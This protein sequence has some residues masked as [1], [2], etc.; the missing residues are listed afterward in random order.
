MLIA[1]AEFTRSQRAGTAV[2][3][4]GKRS[5]KLICKLSSISF[6]VLLAT[7][8]VQTV[9]AA[10]VADANVAAGL[11]PTIINNPGMATQVDIQ[12]PSAGGVSRNVY[13]QFDVDRNG[14]ILNNSQHGAF[15][16]NGG[17]VAGNASL[18]QGAA[19]IILNEVNSSNP[20]QLNGLIE[21]AG[22]NAQVV[23][24]NPSGITCNGCGFINAN[25]ATLTTGQAQI[26]DGVLTGYRVEGGEVVVE[27]EPVWS[28][29]QDYT[30]I[31]ARSVKINT[32]MFAN[33]LKITTGLNNVDATNTNITRLDNAGSGKAPELSL[34]VSSL[35]GMYAGKITLVGTEKGVGVS[36]AGQIMADDAL[37]VLNENG[38]I[39]NTRY[40]QGGETLFLAAKNV[41]NEGE[42]SSEKAIEIDSS[43]AVTNNGH[44]STYSFEDGNSGITIKAASLESRGDI[45]TGESWQKTGNINIDTTDK[46]IATGQISAGGDLTMQGKTVNLSGSNTQANNIKLIARDGMLDTSN[47][48]VEASRQL[49]IA[50]GKLNNKQGILFGE[51]VAVTT[52]DIDNEYGNIYSRSNFKLKGGSIT[53]TG[54]SLVAW[55]SL[56]ITANEINNQA[57]RIYS[58]GGDVR[59]NVTGDV[60]NTDG[61]QIRANGKLLITAGGSVD[62][63]GEINSGAQLM[64]TAKNINNN[65]TLY[66]GNSIELNSD[67]A[68]TN[69]GIIQAEGDVKIAAATLN[70]RGTISARDHIR[71]TGNINIRTTGALIATGQNL[72]NGNLTMQGQTLDLSGSTTQA[73]NITLAASDTLNTSH[74]QVSAR[75]QLT[76]TAQKIDNKDGLLEAKVISV[77]ADSLDNQA[78]SILAISEL[79]L[80]ATDI[81]NE[82]GYVIAAGKDIFAKAP[83]PED[84]APSFSEWDTNGD[85]YR[86]ITSAI[87]RR[88]FQGNTLSDI[89]S[90]LYGILVSGGEI[91]S[92][93][94]QSW[95]SSVS[96]GRQPEPYEAAINTVVKILTEKWSSQSVPDVT[97]PANEIVDEN[98][99]IADEIV[100]EDK[101]IVDE[102]VD[103]DKGIADEIVDEDK[104][105]ADEIVDEDKGIA[106]EIVDE[107]KGIADEIVDEDK[108]I[109][110]EIVDEDKGIVDEIVDEDKG[111]A[112]EIVDEDKGI[113]DEIVDEDKGIADEIVD[114]DK[115]IADEIVDEDKGIADEIV[116]EDKGIA[117]DKVP[118]FSEWDTNGDVYREITSVIGQRFFQGNL[119]SDMLSHLYGILVSG[120]E[121][122]SDVI[123]SIVTTV[124]GMGPTEANESAVNTVVRVLTERWS[125]QSA[126]A[127]PE[128]TPP[129]NEIVDED[130]GEWYIPP[131]DIDGHQ[132]LEQ[133]PQS[134]L[135]LQQIKTA[136]S[137]GDIKWQNASK[138]FVADVVNY[139][140]W[141]LAKGGEINEKL[142]HAIAAQVWGMGVTAENDASIASIANIVTANWS[143]K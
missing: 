57:G 43:G 23:I 127:V 41:H 132:A 80:A 30:D 107:D 138:D 5:A 29:N 8:A 64:M 82:Q 112:D 47:A 94:I 88:F 66:A 58:D 48:R 110:D 49:T 113:A 54:G 124:S 65:N 75:Q 136:I 22:Q 26:K 21:V 46:L 102:I 14:V 67:G 123:Q 25:R 9:Q 93:V 100:D 89:L 53:N 16:Q 118:S 115:G 111:I 19:K 10:I 69:N 81:N 24:A 78:G 34:D 139:F 61:S 135:T 7:G 44:I 96:G 90:H 15:T 27:G 71:G 121:I 119:L 120:G 1:V 18:A 28:N 52:G 125:G 137:S 117:D 63:A 77:T 50:S 45:T 6:G 20:S 33:D 68:V 86:E 122:D 12:A 83:V 134:A 35:G 129:A 133:W 79:A 70:S 85:V 72:A 84:K 131:M 76:A 108:G 3:S 142:V 130:K 128:V 17:M 42:I 97:P 32:Q 59:L 74:A 98:K 31:I 105:I 104:G 92:D 99:G 11:Q 106:D 39:R 51:E 109:A 36:N 55:D 141:T 95:V 60:V 13:S 143:A 73:A 140:A 56:D 2:S 114:E 4:S 103:E 37:T 126:P 38:D 40:M 101:G 87:G 62:N 91:D 116:D